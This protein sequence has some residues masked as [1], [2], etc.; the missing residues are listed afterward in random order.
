MNKPAQ[1]FNKLFLRFLII[2]AWLLII[3]P[4]TSARAASPAPSSIPA[5]VSLVVSPPSFTL[6]AKPG[7]TLQQTVQV[8]NSG[9]SDVTL[10]ALVNDFIVMDNQGTPIRVTTAASGRYLASPWFTLERTS[11]VLKPGATEQVIVIISVPKDAL[12]GGHYAGVFFLDN[13]DHSPGKTA[14]YTAAQ[15]GSLFKITVAGNIKYDATIKSF[16]VDNH[17]YEFGPVNFAAAIENQSDTQISPKA[18]IAVYDMVGRKLVDLPLDQVNIF[19]FVSR[20]LS[21]TWNTVWGFGRYT[22]TL[23]AAY[24]PSGAVASRTLEFWIM[25]YRLMAAIGVVIMVL[26]VIFILIRRHLKSRSDHRDEEIENLKR[27]I[28]EMENRQH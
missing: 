5:T 25:P 26:L 23:T 20:N 17:L 24:G 10:Q 22:A 1:F 18:S 14:S 2:G 16:S 8:T 7:D 13:P 15:V 4:I 27:K 3:T 11:L 21:A 19:P 12:P 9:T 28:V 6:D